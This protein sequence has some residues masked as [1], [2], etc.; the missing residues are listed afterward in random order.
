MFDKIAAY[1]KKW[2][3]LE[4]GDQVIVG[5]SGGADSVCLLFVLHQLQQ[6]LQL[7]LTGVHVNHGLRGSAADADEAF[8][9]QL[10]E[11]LN[12]PCIIYHKNIK[13]IARERRRSEEEAGRE[14]RREVFAEE[15]RKTGGTKIALAHHQNDNAETLLLNLARGTGLRGLGGMHPVKE[16]MIRPLLCVTRQ[17]IENWLAEQGISY[18]QDETN[19]SDGYTRNRIRNRVIPVLEDGVNI[20]TV[21]HISH[22]MEQLREVQ[23]YLEQ[24]IDLFYQ[25]CVIIK[26]AEI[27]LKKAPYEAA[28]QIIRRMLLKRIL[29][30]LARAGRDIGG[31]H[32]ESAEAL[33]DLQVGR[34]VQL[35]YQIEAIRC[36]EGIRFVKERQIDV[37]M[38]VIELPLNQEVRIGNQLVR[39]QVKDAIAKGGKTSEKLYTKQFDY[40]I[41][42]S[43]VSIRTREAGDYIVIDT[44]GRRQKLKSFFINEK[45]PQ[46]EREQILLIAEGNHVLWIVGYRRSMAYQVNEYTKKILEIEIHD[47]TEEKDEREN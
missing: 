26:E 18:C 2:N 7:G 9:K 1:I 35:P 30:T 12:I 3:M 46:E 32:L 47:I 42:K 13:E 14:V 37:S 44:K 23:Q 29:E 19:S 36:Y 34:K 6:D 8:V 22:T 5:I 41:I 25:N 16:Q 10:C 40:D 28:P 17:E 27:I 33:M 31:V 15:L 21:P 11:Q 45:I 24:Q 38:A 4:P 43:D 20:K 39:T